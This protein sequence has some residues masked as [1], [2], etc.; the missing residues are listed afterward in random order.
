MSGRQRRRVQPASSCVRCLCRPG[1]WLEHQESFSRMTYPSTLAAG[2]ERFWVKFGSPGQGEFLAEL[3]A[4]SYCLHV[5]AVQE[6]LAE[7]IGSER[8]G[9]L[10]ELS[11]LL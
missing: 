3:Q 4:E 8:V 1:S 10:H 5:G 7:D 6:Q 9:T 11:H 2:R